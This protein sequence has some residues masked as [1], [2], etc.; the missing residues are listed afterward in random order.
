MYLLIADDGSLSLQE[1]EEM[2]SFCVVE[3][4]NAPEGADASSALSN[5]AEPID[6]DHFWI[7]ASSVIELSPQSDD[8][9]WVNGFWDMLKKVEPYGYSDM[10][11]KRIKAHV[12]IRPK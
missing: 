9:Q 1:H 11:T 8:P 4:A 12:E 10:A 2:K 6:N 3:H 5:I 7:N